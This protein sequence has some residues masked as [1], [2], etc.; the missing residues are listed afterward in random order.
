MVPF[1]LRIY[2]WLQ[3]RRRLCMWLMVALTAVLIVMVASLKYN[4]NIYDFL[5]VSGNEQK[6]ITLYQDISGG[7]RVF[8]MFRM[9]DRSKAD[10]T[11]QADRLTEAV[12]SFANGLQ[13]LKERGH[14][15]EVTSQVDFE[16]VM[17][18]TD[19]V[20]QN[21][22]LMLRDSDYV[23]ME[24]L[25]ATPDYADDQLANDVQM[26]MMPAT[27]MFTSNISNDPLAIFNNV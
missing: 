4:E 13:P 21:M 22:P 25:L 17:G 20:Y 23:R 3:Q 14:I 8:A 27:G 5:P 19:F 9:K 2:D 11:E 24:R 12:D 16:K 18:I 15:T 6:A 1:F 10:D 7:Q 26:I